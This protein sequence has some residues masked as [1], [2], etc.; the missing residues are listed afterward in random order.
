MNVDSVLN[1]RINLYRAIENSVQNILKVALSLVF[2]NHTNGFDIARAADFV[3]KYNL[4]AHSTTQKKSL[5]VQL[6][7]FS[8]FFKL[9]VSIEFSAPCLSF[10]LPSQLTFWFF[11]FQEA[12]PHHTSYLS[13]QTTWDGQTCLT[14]MPP[15]KL[16]I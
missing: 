9:Q 12:P 3:L 1:F 15:T 6:F 16:L 13:S 14:T 11:L 5:F 10:S 2:S 4:S 7:G 8:I